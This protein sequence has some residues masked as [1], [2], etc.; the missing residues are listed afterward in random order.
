[1]ANGRKGNVIIV[2]V[3]ELLIIFGLLKTLNLGDRIMTKNQM[4]IKIPDMNK[5]KRGKFYSKHPVTRVWKRNLIR[6]NK[7]FNSY[8]HLED[9][10]AS[11][12]KDGMFY[13]EYNDKEDSQF[14]LKLFNDSL[15]ICNL[16]DKENLMVIEMGSGVGNLVEMIKKT[17]PQ[18][19]FVLVDI[20]ESL[21]FSYHYLSSLFDGKVKLVQSNDELINIFDTYDIVLVPVFIFEEC[22]NLRKYSFDMFFNMRSFGE[23]NNKTLDYY[24]DI[25]FNKLDI[26]Y[27][28][29]H[30]K[31]L[32]ICNK[33][34]DR[35]RFLENGCFCLLNKGKV[36][37]F[38]LR[39]HLEGMLHEELFLILD[40]KK[41]NIYDEEFIK[42]ASDSLWYKD[43]C[44]NPNMTSSC[45]NFIDEDMSM[46]GTFFRLWN[47]CR[48]YDD[49]VAY[50][51]LIK[52]LY[53]LG[54][55]WMFDEY[56]YFINDYKKV[57]GKKYLLYKNKYKHIQ[58]F[59]CFFHLNYINDKLRYV[60]KKF[61]NIS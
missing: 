47:I 61:I 22:T 29:F 30:N 24:Y 12:I 2:N 46:D 43:F 60:L 36:L 13:Q 1:L 55:G 57:F 28:I 59:L 18:S 16:T 44:D 17:K 52:Y 6:I 45:L 5:N 4:D 26:N 38:E 41:K 11:V 8:L 34:V 19:K 54:R 40:A 25:L 53:L 35:H 42:Q 51:M 37:H 56:Y 15:E 58:K 39:K 27:F 49:E 14:K 48:S 33:Y 20:Y 3:M 23:I 10:I 31:F 7:I 21:Y 50:D 9:K 32:N